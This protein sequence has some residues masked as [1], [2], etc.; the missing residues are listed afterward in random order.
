[1]VSNSP[2]SSGSGPPSEKPDR[3]LIPMIFVGLLA[4]VVIVVVLQMT[5]KAP[6]ETN[7]I[8]ANGNIADS[9]ANGNARPKEKQTNG[10]ENTNA[11]AESSGEKPIEIEVTLQSLA[12]VQKQ[13]LVITQ[14]S[15]SDASSS[16]RA[17]YRRDNT[18]EIATTNVDGFSLHLD[19]L[20]IVG[21]KSLIVHAD[22]QNLV[23]FPKGRAILFFGRTQQGVWEVQ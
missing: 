3:D 14:Q 4:L 16:A 9:N 22:Q 1:M 13:W 12:D 23:V 18:F 21:D 10:N 19:D 15:R 11:S 6:P 2:A 20:P 5:A 8:N 7:V 17:T